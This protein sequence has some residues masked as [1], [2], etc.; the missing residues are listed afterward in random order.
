MELHVFT[1]ISLVGGEIDKKSSFELIHSLGCVDS[2][3]VAAIF[4]DIAH[5][6]ECVK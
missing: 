5:L 1:G 6:C 2:E 3:Q 4:A